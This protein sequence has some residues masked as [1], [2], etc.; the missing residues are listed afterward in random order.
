MFKFL[1]RLF[2]SDS[3]MPHG[4]C[5]LWQPEILWLHV[6]SDAIIAFS[7]FS[8]PLAIIYLA[9]KRRDLPFR[10]IFGLAGAFI[11]LCGSTHLMSIWV[12]WHPDYGPEGLLKAITAGVSLA[13]AALVW[14]MLPAALQLPSATDLKIINTSLQ[15]TNASI[16]EEVHRRTNELR[17]VNDRLVE[18][19]GALQ[20]ALTDAKAAS[21][22]KSEFLANMSHEIR[23]PMNALVGLTHILS[24]DATLTTRQAECIRTMDISA[25]ALMDLLNDLLDIAKIEAGHIELYDKPFNLRAVLNDAIAIMTVRARE[26]GLTLSLQIDDDLGQETDGNDFIGD[27]ARLRQILTNL[28]SNAIKFTAQGHVTLRASAQRLP[29][30]TALLTLEVADTGIGIAEEN[31][32]HIF[33][34]FVQADSTISR[35]YGGSGLGLSISRSLVEQMNGKIGVNSVLGEGASFVINLEVPMTMEAQIRPVL[36]TSAPKPLE[37]LP[38]RSVQQPSNG[39]ILLV[40]DWQPNILVAELML[41]MLN[42]EYAVARSGE[43]AVEMFEKGIYDAVLMDIQLPGIDG[44]EA[45]RRIRAIE[46]SRQQEPVPIIATTAYAMKNDRDKCLAAGMEHYLSKP[47]DALMLEKI[48]KMVS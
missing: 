40:E 34:K 27:P 24:K 4:H 37:Q 8:I 6:F 33:E 3:F 7:Y 25:T 26:K 30:G 36:L 21:L 20:Q 14:R 42:Y 23:T 47:L 12:L 39:K 10:H 45:T 29:N 46:A 11:V 15:Q 43:V 41:E 35:R 5:F 18:N 31:L 9:Y 1:L 38:P 19:E 22:A 32:P 44:L 2:N 17:A 13:T 48:L 28:L 16:E